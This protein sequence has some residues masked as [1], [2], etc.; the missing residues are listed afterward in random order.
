M[1]NP[2]KLYGR[3]QLANSTLWEMPQ[4]KQPG[5]LHK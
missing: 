2:I 5:F 4:Y 3:M 1:Q